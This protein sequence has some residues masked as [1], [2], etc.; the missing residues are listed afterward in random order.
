MTLREYLY[1]DF[2][3][4]NDIYDAFIQIQVNLLEG[5]IRH[6]ESADQRQLT[7]L[8]LEQGVKADEAFMAI[9]NKRDALAKVIR[10]RFGFQEGSK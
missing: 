7:R 4:S 3:F 8:E 2:F 10:A 1:T 5:V 9:G 6:I